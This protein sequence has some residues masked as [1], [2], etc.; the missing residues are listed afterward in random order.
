[1]LF[2]KSLNFAVIR[3]NSI[4]QIYS[5]TKGERANALKNV[6]K[7][8]FDVGEQRCKAEKNA[9]ANV[10]EHFKDSTLITDNIKPSERLKDFDEIHTVTVNFGSPEICDQMSG[11]IYMH[12]RITE[13]KC[14]QV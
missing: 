8:L 2:K 14:S 10:Y 13:D 5:E 9:T 3:S 1:M 12:A 11:A 4:R 6:S 7:S